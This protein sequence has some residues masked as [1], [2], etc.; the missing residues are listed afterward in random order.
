MIL[1][2][3]PSQSK[4]TANLVAQMKDT[5]LWHLLELM[6]LVPGHHRVLSIVAFIKLLATLHI[7]ISIIPK[8]LF[9]V[10]LPGIRNAS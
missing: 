7:S 1:A 5:G 2:P 8:T 10:S 6:C 4:P 3:C 9:S